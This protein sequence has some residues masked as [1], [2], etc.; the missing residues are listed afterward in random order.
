MPRRLTHEEI[1]ERL[2][3]AGWHPGRDVG[4]DV[5]ELMESAAAELRSH[6]YSVSPF[7]A[8]TDFLREFA[9]LDL[10]SPGAP[11]QEHCVFEVRFVD[12]I[13]AEQIA[14]LSELLEQP[15]FPVAFERMERGTAVMD[16]LGRVFYTHWSGYY[17]LGEER[18]DVLNSLLTGD[19][20]DAEEFYV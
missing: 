9:F 7:P 15:L 6:G 3:A 20:S 8:V 12:A 11:P 19:Q 14:E 2:R 4:E 18:D 13:R 1:E 16:P 5:G 10:E 17:Y